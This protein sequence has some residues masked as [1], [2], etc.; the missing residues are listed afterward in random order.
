MSYHVSPAFFARMR[1]TVAGI[2]QLIGH[3][4]GAEW[5]MLA[6]HLNNHVLQDKNCKI[7]S[8]R[9]LDAAED[10]MKALN[11]VFFRYDDGKCKYPLI[12]K[13]EV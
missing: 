5:D 4:E 1:E 10:G 9:Q 3:Y 7:V 6:S 8:F 11:S 2:E 13:Y 12:N